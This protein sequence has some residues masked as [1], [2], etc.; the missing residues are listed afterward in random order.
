V[1]LSVEQAPRL[2]RLL[3]YDGITGASMYPG[4]DGV[5]RAMRERSLWDKR[6]GT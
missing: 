3:A 2:L 4:T 5:V 6:E 1:T